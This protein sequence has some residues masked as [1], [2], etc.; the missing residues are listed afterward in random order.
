[1]DV[2]DQRG[3]GLDGHQRT[4]VACVRRT[5]A[6]GAGEQE[7]RTFGTMTADRLALSDWLAGDAVEPVAM[8]ATR[9]YWRPVFTVREAG[10]AVILVTPQHMRAVPGRTTTVREAE[11]R[12]DRLAHGLLRPCFIPASSPL[13]PRFIPASSR[14]PRYGRGGN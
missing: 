4:V 6:Q 13:H 9:V 5:T 3:A 12:A 10:H 7:V 8:E 14:P 2:R 1:M 11:W